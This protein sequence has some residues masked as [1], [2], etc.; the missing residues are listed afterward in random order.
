MLAAFCF[1]RYYR[2]ESRAMVIEI[3]EPE[4]ENLIRER[5]AS[6]QFKTV[7]DVLMQALQPKAAPLS[8]KQS[9]AQ[10]LLES[11]LR[12]SGLTVE[13]QKDFPQLIDL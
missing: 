4:L 6:G 1:A 12:E 10:F 9:L 8:P 7:E 2:Q 11:P 5:M 3:H 13:R